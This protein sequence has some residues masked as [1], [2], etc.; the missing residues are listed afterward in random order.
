[1]EGVSMLSR[2]VT[3]RDVFLCVQYLAVVSE[4]DEE[5]EEEEEEEEDVSD[6]SS[7]SAE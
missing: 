5:E 7:S 6:V 4:E 2:I 3:S 1:M